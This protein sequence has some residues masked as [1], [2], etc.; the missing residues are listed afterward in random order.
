MR[1]ARDRLKMMDIQ[2]I[3]A[4]SV[5]G[6]ALVIVGR[7]VWRTMTNRAGCAKCCG[8]AKAATQE[9]AADV[10][11]PKNMPLIPINPPRRIDEPTS[12]EQG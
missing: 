11:S 12:S 1:E 6:V 9:T 2:D 3:I 8:C 4:L 7:F 5:S 10:R